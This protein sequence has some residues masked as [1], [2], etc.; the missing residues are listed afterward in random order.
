[1]PV[2]D[3]EKV[4]RLKQILKWHPRGI[5]ITDLAN[6]IEMNRNLVAKYLDILLVS[7]QVEMQ[8]M[9]AAKVYFLSHRVPI[10]SM[11]E[12]SSDMLIILDNALT[13]M[14]VNE[15]LL[16]HVHKTKGEFVGRNIRDIE[17]PFIKAIPV[18]VP[19]R[20]AD[21]A[22]DQV[23]EFECVTEGE[24]HYYRIKQVQTAFEDGAYGII[25]I[26]EDVTSQITYQKTLELNEARYRGIVEDQ[27]EFITR[28][29]T[30]GTLVF[31]NDAYAR[32]L[33]IEKEDLLGKQHIPGIVT[34]D[35]E[36]VHQSILSLDTDNPV[37]SFECR[38]EH[39]CGKVR[40]NLWTVRA[41]FGGNR[42][43]IEYQGVGKDNTE[44]RE[45][46]AR[47][48]QYVKDMEFLSRKAQEFVEISPDADIF[49]AVAKG[50]SEI[51]PDSL[52]T[53]NSIDVISGTLIIRAVLP[54]KDRELLLPCLGKDL[55]DFQFSTNCI[56]KQEKD[57]FFSAMQAGKLVHF[58]EKLHTIF[59]RQI[60]EDTCERIKKDLGLGDDIYSI[61]LSRHGILFGNV[62]F[63]PRKGN[64]IT[65]SSIIDTFVRQA[66]V[67]LHRRMTDDALKASESRYRGIV[68]DQTEFITRFLPDKTF[69][70]VNYSV[71]RFFSKEPD[72]LLGLSI[73]SLIPGEDRDRIVRD[74]QSMVTGN[75]VL[76]IEHRMI[77]PHGRI[78]WMQW[79]YRALFDDRGVIVEYQ[80]VGRDITEQ[81]DAV[82]RIKQ[83]IADV[84][85]LTQTSHEFLELPPD[86]DVYRTICRGV[87]KILPNAVIALS[88]IDTEAAITRAILDD[89]AC[90]VFNAMI[91]GNIIGKSIKLPTGH[92]LEKREMEKNAVLSG[93]LFKIPGNLFFAM[94]KNVPEEI[95]AQIEET[96][97]IGDIHSIGLVSKGIILANMII[98]LR[99]GDKLLHSDLV[100]AYIRQ[101]SIALLRWKTEETLK[102]SEKLYRSVIENIQDVFYR[103][104]TQ[105]N[106]IMASPSW[107]KLLR[108]ASLEECIGY[109]IAEKFYFNP[110]KREEFLDAVYRYGS[111]NDF[112]VVLKCKD[113]SPLHVSTHSHLYHDEAG[114]L[115]G[116]EGI[117]REVSDQRAAAEKI[118]ILPNRDEKGGALEGFIDAGNISMNKKEDMQG[119]TADMNPGSSGG[120]PAEINRLTASPE[121][122]HPP[123]TLPGIVNPFYLSNALK[124]AQDYIVILDRAGKCIWANDAMVSA[125]NAKTCNDLAGRS[126][127][128][129]IAPEFRKIAMDSLMTIKKTGTKTVPFMM[130]SSSGRISVEANISSIITDKGDLFGYMAIARNLDG[131]KTIDQNNKK[132]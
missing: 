27:T 39:S 89:D 58:K 22:Y 94:H 68:E 34:G 85:Y 41:L 57:T 23:G 19:S 123:V 55:L 88:S 24:N 47:I 28:F 62:S 92:E 109:N 98:F 114:S 82:T 125:V 102:K 67:V 99:K 130:L 45:A 87:K 91:G 132:R 11:L 75:P 53:V 113:G 66:A 6:K 21:P 60:P 118:R 105:G 9:G 128:L 48:N 15:P 4:E 33:G 124:M 78:R 84:E 31:V 97:N 7:G 112:E 25:L 18:T 126:I 122:I 101:A 5:T 38:I 54:E 120:V 100:E 81:K 49:Q 14:Q 90:D 3:Q 32:Y 119:E 36:S 95:C 129:Y 2:F 10:S 29:L 13:I 80:G 50:I 74:L 20:G 108:Y 77:D 30:D 63:S 76:T 44:K 26:I 70:Y 56:P 116:I 16:L 73:F 52:I 35:T 12:F 59:F 115:L 64:T 121:A 127:A 40:W 103:S 42:K 107:A 1:M 37:I 17:H 46:A 131:K 86:N 93:K 72:E 8:V 83:Y 43:A 104:D 106:L 110:E 69:S 61:G 111:V 117:F 51:I 65:S 71:C 79:T 96:L